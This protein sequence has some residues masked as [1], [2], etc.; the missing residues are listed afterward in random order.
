MTS[1]RE[2][3]IDEQIRHLSSPTARKSYYDKF[4][5]AMACADAHPLPLKTFVRPEFP[6]EPMD[7]TEPLT[8][9]AGQEEL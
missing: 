1:R 5:E 6:V 4:R 7:D 9:P 3:W 8:P 2:Q